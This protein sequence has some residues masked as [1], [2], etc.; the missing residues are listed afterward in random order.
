MKEIQIYTDYEINLQFDSKHILTVTVFSSKKFDVTL[1]NINL[2]LVLVCPAFRPENTC[3]PG[4][5]C[6]IYGK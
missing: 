1:A 4:E 3:K 5:I 2:L 6:F